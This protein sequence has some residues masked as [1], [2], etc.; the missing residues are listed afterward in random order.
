MQMSRFSMVLVAAV[1]CSSLV[2]P[3]LAMAGDKEQATKLFSEGNELRVAEKYAEALEKYRA[4]YKLL[5]S[6]KIDY[7]IALNLEKMG[8]NAGAVRAY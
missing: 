6:F 2:S 7:N 1:L 4:A 8:S 3:S 5:P